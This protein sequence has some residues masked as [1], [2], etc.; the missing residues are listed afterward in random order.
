MRKLAIISLV[1]IF[2]CNY[3][4]NPINEDAHNACVE[5]SGCNKA[6]LACW[7]N[8]AFFYNR[9]FQEQQQVGFPTYCIIQPK[10][11]K[12]RCLQCVANSVA[13]GDSTNCKFPEFKFLYS[14]ASDGLY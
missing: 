7:M 14:D 3:K 10:L 13:R 4:T 6:A 2:G 5:F 9:K 8:H 12:K 1:F 11:C